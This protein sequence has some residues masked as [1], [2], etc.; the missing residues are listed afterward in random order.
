M[1]GGCTRCGHPADSHGLIHPYYCR[2]YV[3]SFGLTDGEWGC[4]CWGYEQEV[5]S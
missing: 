4:D 5:A 1:S 2:E 3:K